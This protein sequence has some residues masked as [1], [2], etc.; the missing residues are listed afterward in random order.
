MMYSCVGKDINC[1]FD[2]VDYIICQ[3]AMNMNQLFNYALDLGQLL[4]NVK[5]MLVGL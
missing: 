3:Y 4:M 5:I 1:V 2:H